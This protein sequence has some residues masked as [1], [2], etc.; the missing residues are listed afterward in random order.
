MVIKLGKVFWQEILANSK[1][2][3][4]PI[5]KLPEIGGMTSKV[6]KNKKAKA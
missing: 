2:S 3:R 4:D 1:P 6:C 5:S